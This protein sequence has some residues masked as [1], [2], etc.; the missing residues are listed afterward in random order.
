MSRREVVLFSELPV[1]LL[2]FLRKM[3]DMKDCNFREANKHITNQISHIACMIS[4]PMVVEETSS[5]LLLLAIL[6][7]LVGRGGLG[8]VAGDIAE[9]MVVI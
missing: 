2:P 5:H 8:D 7:E 1:P 4:P 3:L 6:D 9:I